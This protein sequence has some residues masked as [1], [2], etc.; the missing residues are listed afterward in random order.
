MIDVIAT[1][2][3][4]LQ[5]WGTSMQRRVIG[6]FVA[7]VVGVLAAQV[8]SAAERLGK[9]YRVG[10]L[11]VS[12]PPTAAGWQQRVPVLQALH[13]LGYVEGQN[14]AMEYRWAEGKRDRLP[15]LAADLV[16]LPV[17]VIIAPS[18][19]EIMA[20]RQATSSIPIVMVAGA[21]PVGVG[22]VASLARP[23][24]N[25]TGTA[26]SPPEIAGKLLQLLTELVPHARRVAVIVNPDFPG[27]TS[28]AQEFDVG[29][30]GLG[31]TA[32]AVLLREPDDFGT[33]WVQVMRDRPDALYVVVDPIVGM[34]MRQ[35]LQLAARLRLP[36]IYTARGP[37]EAGGLM[38]YGP[39]FEAMPRRAAVYVDKILKGTKPADLPIE[40][41]MKFELVINLKTAKALDL[42]IPPSLL[43]QADEVIR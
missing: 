18:N 16:R 5:Q 38:S 25:L 22:F 10:M 41:P 6:L 19:H 26:I 27:M 21:D 2:T 17:D 42:T 28:Y 39:G 24:G 8:V 14:L 4:L 32:D 43:L 36:A 31:V 20:A 23:G 15:E 35:I 37:V 13:D 40:Q 12:Y 7:C 11:S 3:M 30:H 33:A 29:A 1:P 34:H 9:V